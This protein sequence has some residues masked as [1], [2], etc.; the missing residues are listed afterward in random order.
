MASGDGGD[1]EDANDHD[2]DEHGNDDHDDCSDR[3]YS[4]IVMLSLGFM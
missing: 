4:L 3:A 1:D 2:D